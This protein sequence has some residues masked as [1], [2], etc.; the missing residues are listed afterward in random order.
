MPEH[1]PPLGDPVD[2]DAL[3][4]RLRVAVDA[5]ATPITLDEVQ[6]LA[7]RPLGGAPGAAA[8]VTAAADGPG[9]PVELASGGPRDPAPRRRTL[10]LA[11]AA[12]VVVVLGASFAVLR[13]RDESIVTTDVRAPRGFVAAE[14]GGLYDPAA[15]LLRGRNVLAMAASDDLLYVSYADPGD[16][17]PDA[18]DGFVAGL[19]VADAAS[20]RVLAD[21]HLDDGATATALAST[22]PGTGTGTGTGTGLWFVAHRPTRPAGDEL[23][24][25]DGVE[26]PR[27]VDGLPGP[28]QV[29]GDAEGL[30]LIGGG[31]LQQ[32]DPASGA[33]QASSEDTAWVGPSSLAFDDGRRW[34]ATSSGEIVAVDGVARG[35][36]LTAPVTD[37]PFVAAAGG[38]VFALARQRATRFD[39]V[40]RQGLDEVWL[41]T[42]ISGVATD[43]D[44]LWLAANGDAADPFAEVDLAVVDGR[45]GNVTRATLAVPGRSPLVAVVDGGAVMCLATGS[46]PISLA[47]PDGSACRQIPGPGTTADPA[48]PQVDWTAGDRVVVPGTDPTSTTPVGPD[49][50]T[51]A[52]PTT[53][54]AIPT[55][56]A[57]VLPTTSTTANAGPR[58]FDPAGITLEGLAPIRLGMTAAELTAATGLETVAATVCGDAGIEVVGL[59]EGVYVRFRD[60]QVDAVTIR[61][62]AYSTVDGLTVDSSVAELVAR[63]PDA[64]VRDHVTAVQHLVV[65]PDRS[66]AIAF[67]SEGD[68]LTV[69][70][71]IRGAEPFLDLC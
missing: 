6:A 50:A 3:A 13:A 64:E 17:G 18:A 45:T 32:R 21:H 46:Q 58:A 48:V 9:G 41:P 68:D 7:G 31:T 1:Q 65:A 69:I 42:A 5:R 19:L 61:S 63:H 2:D 33:V 29:V 38:S 59:P 24:R 49:P 40:T 66:S 35:P 36:A 39:P 12:L 47:P 37:A 16:A 62:A 4:A 43:G 67:T 52:T 15:D 54:S 28:M 11:A 70:T 55:T 8:A 26:P 34:A 23:W 30:W 51:T 71:V 27:R 22:G 56:T 60:G 44:D 53:T 57:P 25:A 14:P 20:G 10:V